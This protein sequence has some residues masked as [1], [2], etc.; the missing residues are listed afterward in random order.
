MVNPAL[1]KVCHSVASDTFTPHDIAR[2]SCSSE[3]YISG[4]CCIIP[5]INC[6]SDQYPKI[7]LGDETHFNIKVMKVGPLI[8]PFLLFSQLDSV[9]VFEVLEGSFNASY[10]DA[11]IH[12]YV[13]LFK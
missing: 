4:T 12:R 13:F 9:V 10:R 2:V 6:N 5:R 7:A 1:C 3:R 8:P 11:S